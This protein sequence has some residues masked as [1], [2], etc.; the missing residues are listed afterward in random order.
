MEKYTPKCQKLDIIVVFDTSQ[1]VVEPFVRDYADFSIDFISQYTLSGAVDG[2][3]TRT[4]I[5]S[6]NSDVQIV[7]ELGERPLS[8]FK[9]AVSGIHYTGGT[10]NTL[11]AMK[12]GRDMFMRQGGTTHGRAMVFLSD[13]QPYPMTPDTWA[14]IVSVGNDLKGLGVDVFFVGDDNGYD[15]ATK[16]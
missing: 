4:G 10:T 1:S 5:I 2:D 6:F 7:R 14:E 12:A 15:D 8:D 9:T 16:N 3:N 11:A 13:G